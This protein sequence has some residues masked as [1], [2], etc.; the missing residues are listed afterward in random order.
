[1]PQR[2]DDKLLRQIAEKLCDIRKELKITQVT[3]FADTHVRISNIESGKMN[4]TIMSI[5]ILCEYYGVSLEEFF[6]GIET[7][8]LNQWD[9]LTEYR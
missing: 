3:V 9:K 8:H 7:G 4:P 5:A 2:H 1:M 6:Q